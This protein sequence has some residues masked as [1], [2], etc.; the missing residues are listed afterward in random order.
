MNTPSDTAATGTAPTSPGAEPATVIR[1]RG[2]TKT[3]EDDQA[4][5]DIDLDVRTGEHVS[6]IG[7]SGSGKS[8]LLRCINL[9]EVPTSGQIQ[10]VGETVFRTGQKPRQRKLVKLRQQVGM[11]FQNFNLF[12]HLSAIDN[13]AIPLIRG[14]GLDEEAALGRAVDLLDKVDL[15]DK[16][17]QFPRELSGGQQQRVAIA[18][19]L[20]LRP[21]ALL[22]DEPTSALD[23][24]LVGEVLEVMREIAAEGM[25]MVI[26]THELRFAAEV[27]DRMIFLDEGRI[28]EA[29]SPEQVLQH[30]DR[31][32]TK[33]FVSQVFQ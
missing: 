13:V 25:T 24:E 32:R 21:V 11:V 2:I 12:P 26:V 9:L 8:T 6:I 14:L 33:A 3:F 27:S 15:R 23:P 17:L 18:R 7:R 19:A 5:A 22:F 1:L 29:G 28:V 30:P 16:L 31:E 10:I 20:A 4:L